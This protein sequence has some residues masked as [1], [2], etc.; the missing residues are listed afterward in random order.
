MCR[1]CVVAQAIDWLMY[2]RRR[3]F[4]GTEGA[5]FPGTVHRRR[6]VGVQAQFN[7]IQDLTELI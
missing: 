4:S 6:T 2:S 5:I 3:G 7:F 1:V